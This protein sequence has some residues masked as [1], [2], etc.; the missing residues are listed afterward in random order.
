MGKVYRYIDVHDNFIKYVLIVYGENRTLEQ[1]HREHIKNDIWCDGNFKVQYVHY[2]SGKNRIDS[3]SSYIRAKRGAID[4]KLS[5]QDNYN[6]YQDK[7]YIAH[8]LGN[9]KLADQF[10]VKG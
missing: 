1:R 4:C 2:N 3:K 9:T 5:K 10:P 8:A 6:E 7:K